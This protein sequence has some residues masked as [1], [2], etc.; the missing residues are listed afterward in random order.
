[1]NSSSE[2]V[3]A[4]AYKAIQNKISGLG[5]RDYI[6]IGCFIL[7]LV[8][9]IVSISLLSRYLGNNDDWNSLKPK[10]TQISILITVGIILFWL[11]TIIYL[12]VNDTYSIYFITTISCAALAMSLWGVVVSTITR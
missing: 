2:S 4:S 5:V 12:T 8:F 10:I 11:G 6:Y 1:M 9:F 3:G 7:S